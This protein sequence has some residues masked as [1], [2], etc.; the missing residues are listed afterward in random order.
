[1][2][3]VSELNIGINYNLYKLR[4]YPLSIIALFIVLSNK[5]NIF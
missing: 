1:M 3:N 4:N 2:D 5:C